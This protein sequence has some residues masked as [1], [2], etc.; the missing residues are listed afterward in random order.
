[1]TEPTRP[2]QAKPNYLTAPF[3][4]TEGPPPST[5]WWYQ[6]TTPPTA[7]VLGGL[8]SGK[9]HPQTPPAQRR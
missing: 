4:T 3:A 9:S 2:E 8:G 6:D 7:P 1:M 5:L